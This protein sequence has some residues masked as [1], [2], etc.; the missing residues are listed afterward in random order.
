MWSRS[1]SKVKVKVKVKGQSQGQGQIQIWR[2]NKMATGNGSEKPETE[3]KEP[4][5]D[6]V[7]SGGKFKQTYYD[8]NSEW[9][10]H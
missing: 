8:N 1:R 9:Y 7:K 10:P 3:V 4:E 5:T 6:M 2:V